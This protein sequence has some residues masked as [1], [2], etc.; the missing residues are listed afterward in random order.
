LLLQILHQTEKP[1]LIQNDFAF[2]GKQG[3]VAKWHQRIS[4]SKSHAARSLTTGL[5]ILSH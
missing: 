1:R 3:G 5:I 4:T 2:G